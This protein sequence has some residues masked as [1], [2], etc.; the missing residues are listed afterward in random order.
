MTWEGNQGKTA[1]NIRHIQFPWFWVTGGTLFFLAIPA[2]DIGL[3]SSCVTYFAFL[4]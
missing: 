3:K 2:H 4:T 1:E